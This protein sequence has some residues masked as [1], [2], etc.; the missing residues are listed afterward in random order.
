ML[1]LKYMLLVGA[2]ALFAV[3]IGLIASIFYSQRQSRRGP[4]GKREQ[5]SQQHRKNT[6]FRC[7]ASA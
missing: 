3:G 5:T 7:R 6:L 2:V 1:F 4:E